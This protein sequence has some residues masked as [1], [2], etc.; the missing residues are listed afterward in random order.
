MRRLTWNIALFLLSYLGF[1]QR[2]HHFVISFFK[3]KYTPKVFC[4]GDAKTGTTSLHKALKILGCRSVRLFDLNTWDKRGDE[5]YI[6]KL[7]KCNYEAFV[8]L[9]MGYK[10]LYQKIDKAIPNSKFILTIRDKQS[11]EKSFAN[12]YRG[13]SWERD[14]RELAQRVQEFEERNKQVVAYFRDKPSQLLIMNIFEG[15][16]WTELCSFLNKPILDMPFP[17]KNKGKYKK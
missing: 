1:Y 8:D 17:H 7:Q 11:F 5:Q 10:D 4:I 16:G 14:S 13:S 2:L 15:D 6:K 12:F 3:K 9:P